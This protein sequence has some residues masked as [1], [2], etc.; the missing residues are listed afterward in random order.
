MDDSVIALVS[1]KG[2]DDE[3]DDQSICKINNNISNN[4][5][6]VSNISESKR[7]EKTFLSETL[8]MRSKQTTSQLLT[9]E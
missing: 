6:V 2:L 9:Q 7:E 4:N 5:N 8:K 3:D 1:Y